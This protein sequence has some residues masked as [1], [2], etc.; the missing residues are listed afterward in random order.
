ML[1]ESRALVATQ[2]IGLV[3]LDELGLTHLEEL[4]VSAVKN[5]FSG[6]VNPLKCGDA[7]D[8]DF[9]D[10]VYFCELVEQVTLNVA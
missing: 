3:H 5:T 9:V 10:E 2:V 6:Y 4:L 7:L 8:S 1:A